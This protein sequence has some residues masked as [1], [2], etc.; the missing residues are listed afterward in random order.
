MVV[1]DRPT[2]LACFVDRVRF[3]A[4]AGN[5]Y[6]QNGTKR[7][8]TLQIGRLPGRCSAL[9]SVTPTASQAVLPTACTQRCMVAR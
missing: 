5:G 2:C 3:E 9:P 6:W 7:T 4:A 8:A 1:D